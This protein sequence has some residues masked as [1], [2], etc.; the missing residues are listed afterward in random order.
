[1]LVIVL[2]LMKNCFLNSTF[3]SGTI[4]V[5]SLNQSMESG[6]VIAPEALHVSFNVLPRSTCKVPVNVIPENSKL[7]SNSA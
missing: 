3:L 5:P 1:M 6:G 7:K 4:F 2:E